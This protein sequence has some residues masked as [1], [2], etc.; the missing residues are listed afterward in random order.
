MTTQQLK[1]HLRHLGEANLLIV[2][3][4]ARIERERL[5]LAILDADGHKGRKAKNSLTRF[6]N[7]LQGML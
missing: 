4:R 1:Q 2:Q 7:T 6:E 5:L 3:T